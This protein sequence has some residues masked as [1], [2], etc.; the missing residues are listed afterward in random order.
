MRRQLGRLLEFGSAHVFVVKQR[1]VKGEVVRLRK[2][3]GGE[4][5]L[6]VSLVLW[7]DGVSVRHVL[8]SGFSCRS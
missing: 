6:P 3:L 4:G 8:A 2:E 5:A 7:A 1:G